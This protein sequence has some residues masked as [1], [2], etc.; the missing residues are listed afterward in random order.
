[1]PVVF[2]TASAVILINV[3]SKALQGDFFGHTAFESVPPHLIN[4]PRMERSN[5]NGL[6]LVIWLEAFLLWLNFQNAFGSGQYV[7]LLLV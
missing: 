5:D 6:Q 4:N 2:Q 3:L 7:K 1:M